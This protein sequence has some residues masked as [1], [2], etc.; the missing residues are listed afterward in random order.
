M[1]E[2]PEKWTMS[3]ITSG[4]SNESRVI[5]PVNEKDMNEFLQLIMDLESSGG[6]DIYQSKGLEENKGA[7]LF[8]LETGP[9]QGGMTRLTRAYTQLPEN[10]TPKALAKHYKEAVDSDSSYD[11]K[12]KLH[13]HQQKFL[14]AANIMLP[15]GGRRKYDEWIASG[16]SKEKFI[17]WWLDS[18]WKGW[19]SDK[20]YPTDQEKYEVREDKK[21]WAKDQLGITAIDKVIEL[22]NKENFLK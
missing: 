5:N 20:K 7:G 16:K 21:K 8:Q 12:K 18:H 13:P 17:D 19:A 15:E 11:V 4:W 6:K 14:M 10:L 9:R 3:S 2:R 1:A 22:E